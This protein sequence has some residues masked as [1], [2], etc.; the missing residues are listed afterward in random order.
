MR[1]KKRKKIGGSTC[2]R[3]RVPTARFFGSQF[4][5]CEPLTSLTALPSKPQWTVAAEGAPQVDAGASVQARVGVAEVPFGRA[6]WDAGRREKNP[7]K[8]QCS[9]TQW[10]PNTALAY[11]WGSPSVNLTDNV[12]KH[13]KKLHHHF[14][15]FFFFLLLFAIQSLLQKNHGHFSVLLFYA[16]S[17]CLTSVGQ[18]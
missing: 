8:R 14:E 5:T 3:S 7:V 17:Y 18:F 1:G 15:C 10:G 6:S 13:V 12:T 4:A 11:G 2:L 9:E 16:P